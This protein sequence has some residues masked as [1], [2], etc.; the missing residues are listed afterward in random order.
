MFFHE[1]NDFRD[2]FVVD[3]TVLFSKLCL[4]PHRRCANIPQDLFTVLF[5]VSAQ[6]FLTAPR[7]AT[8]R[9]GAAASAVSVLCR[10]VRTVT[11]IDAPVIMYMV[12]AAG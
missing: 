8:A 9:T 5:G 10:T 7:P 12:T 2:E 11:G 3:H 1:L 6:C 4:C